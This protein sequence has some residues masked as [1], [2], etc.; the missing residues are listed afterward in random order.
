MNQFEQILTEAGIRPTAIRQ[1]VL[2][3]I[4]AYDH[5]FTLNEME[6]RIG[7]IDRSTLFRTLMLFVGR[8]ILHDIDNGSGSK[9]FCRC[10]CTHSHHHAPHIHFTC[11]VCHETFC[12]KDIDISTIPLPTG[13]EVTEVNLVMK[14]I[15]PK[16]KKLK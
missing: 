2:K 9:L 1:M 6:Q 14:G 16:C 13:Y 12:I 11:T 10:E 5:T 7:T 4:I 3:E 15:C 8:K